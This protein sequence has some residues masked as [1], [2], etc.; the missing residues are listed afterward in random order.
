MAL[1]VTVRAGESLIVNDTTITAGRQV[2]L[3]ITGA[4]ADITFPNGRKSSGLSAAEQ[5]AASTEN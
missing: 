1:V 2:S 5:P 4:R 3:R